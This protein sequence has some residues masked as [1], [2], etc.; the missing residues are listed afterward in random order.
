LSSSKIPTAWKSA[1]V[2]PVFKKGLSSDPSN[3]RPISLTSSACKIL[4]SIIKD[5]ILDHLL[6]NNLLSKQQ[7]GFLSKRSTT[8][9]VLESSNAWHRNQSSKHQT[10]IV[11][12]D[13]AKAFDS[14]VSAKLLHKLNCYGINSLP[15]NWIQEFASNR[16]QRVKVGSSLSSPSLVS[17]GVPQGSVLGPILFFVFIND[18]C[19]LVTN[20]VEIKLFADDVKL[21]LEITDDSSGCKIQSCLDN[22]SRWCNEWQLNLS[23]TKCAVLSIGYKGFDFCYKVNNIAI[24]HVSSFKD[25]GVTIDQSLSFENHIHTICATASQRAALILKCFTSRQP[26]LLIRA[27]TTYVRPLLEYAS[28]IWSPFKLNLIDK[29]ESVQRHFTKN[30]MVFIISLMMPG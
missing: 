17:S 16:T 27:F 19:N 15:L 11:Y 14:V 2:T 8:S 20:D 24:Q 23:P 4:E 30:F 5:H 7:Y 10:D 21:Y 6:S 29:I 9:Q 12:L 22:I 3:Y 26:A 13:F 1:I 18:I 25:L 28:C